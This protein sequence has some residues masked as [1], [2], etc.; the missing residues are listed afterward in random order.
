MLLVTLGLTTLTGTSSPVAGDTFTVSLNSGPGSAFNA[1]D[2]T[3]GLGTLPIAFTPASGKV[4]IVPAAVVVPEPVGA[5]AI[6]SL[7][8]LAGIAVWQQRRRRK[9]GERSEEKYE[10]LKAEKLKS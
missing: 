4:T 7:L 2:P 3:T 8:P 5:V 6:L 10:K 9:S 1:I